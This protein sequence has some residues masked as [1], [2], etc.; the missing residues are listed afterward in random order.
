M[1][2]TGSDFCLSL[3]LPLTPSGKKGKAGSSRILQG[4]RRR[5]HRCSLPA[6]SDPTRQFARLLSPN[7]EYESQGYG[8]SV[9]R[10]GFAQHNANDILVQ[11]LA[12][13]GGGGSPCCQRT[14]THKHNDNVIYIFAPNSLRSQPL[15]HNVARSIYFSQ[16]FA[17]NVRLICI[18]WSG[19]KVEKDFF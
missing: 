8:A 3:R 5:I 2:F 19:G 7:V 13:G 6:A 17:T 9:D 12:G 18:P 11:Q 1:S 4:I 16:K 14:R 15:I 10:V